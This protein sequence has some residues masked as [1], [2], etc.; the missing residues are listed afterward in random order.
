MLKTENI[1]KKIKYIIINLNICI[2]VIQGTQWAKLPNGLN[3][4]F[5]VRMT[6]TA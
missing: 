5:W 6:L 1:N 3:T 4:A 2:K